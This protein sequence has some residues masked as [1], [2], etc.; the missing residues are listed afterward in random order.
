MEIQVKDTDVKNQNAHVCPESGEKFA[1]RGAIPGEKE[2]SLKEGT[3]RGEKE[4][5]RK[6]GKEG[7]LRGEKEPSLVFL[8]AGQGSQ[9][10]GMGLDFYETFEGYRDWID[11]LEKLELGVD[12]RR[13]MHEG[14][15]EELSQTQN[16]QACMAAFA[17]GVTMLLAESGIIPSA[18]C[19][20][21]LGEYGALYSAG[22]FEAE[23]Y[24]RIVAFRG[25]AMMEAAKG[26]KCSMSA[27]LGLD[28]SKVKEICQA[29]VCSH[30][31]RP[32]SEDPCEKAQIP[33]PQNGYYVTATNFNCPGQTVICG[34]ESAVT[35]VETILKANGAKRCV[36]LN[37]SGPFHTKYMKLAGDTLRGYLEGVE[38]KNPRIPVALNVTGSLWENLPWEGEEA[39]DACRILSPLPDRREISGRITGNE[40]QAVSGYPAAADNKSLSLY[41]QPDVIKDLLKQQVQTGVRLEEDL[42]ALL[43]AGY[44]DFIEIGPGN[45][46]AGFLKK[47]A[48]KLGLS[49]RVQSI[50][51]VEDFYKVTGAEKSV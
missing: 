11:S 41:S 5:S 1:L 24:V 31:D 6:D 4:T 37:V 17:A 39:G 30:A 32:A 3:L 22:V 23:D 45:A 48:K 10:V 25:K 47:T 35:E 21:S 18:A 28:G 43:T 7:T 26:Q 13:L 16:T 12:L 38:F 9:H 29:Y 46:M 2:R 36:R 40:N 44:R 51:T 15:L 8:Y 34:D 33:E 19:G 14:P 49:V 27:V 42:T 20:L 50:D